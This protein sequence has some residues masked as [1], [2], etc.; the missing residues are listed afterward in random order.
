LLLTVTA[1]AG[2]GVAWLAGNSDVADGAWI[3]GTLAGLVPAIGWVIEPMTVLPLR[4]VSKMTA[5]LHSN[6]HLAWARFRHRKLLDFE[7]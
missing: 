6:E 1:L 3:V 7:R 2:G 4:T 5:G